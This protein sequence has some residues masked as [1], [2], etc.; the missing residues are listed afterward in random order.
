MVTPYLEQPPLH[1][2]SAL[3]DL[4]APIW[5][6]KCR[7]LCRCLKSMQKKTSKA[8]WSHRCSCCPQRAHG[9]GRCLVFESRDSFQPPGSLFCFLNLILHHCSL[10]SAF[11]LKVSCVLTFPEPLGLPRRRRSL[12]KDS[13]AVLS[14]QSWGS[15]ALVWSC[16]P[17]TVAPHREAHQKP[18]PSFCKIGVLWSSSPGV[19]LGQSPASV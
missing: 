8:L 12:L 10:G 14:P 7:I 9:L 3:G 1:S 6:S 16:L 5:A 15:T 4:E 2:G 17:S 18:L 13:F 19:G 11:P